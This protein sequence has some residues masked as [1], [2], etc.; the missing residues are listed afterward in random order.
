MAAKPR[1]EAENDWRVV[2]SPPLLC[3][4][5]MQ[6]V[7][8]SVMQESRRSAVHMVPYP[9]RLLRL[10]SCPALRQEAVGVEGPAQGRSDLAHL[11]ERP[12]A[13]KR[14]RAPQKVT[15]SRKKDLWPPSILRQVDQ[16]AL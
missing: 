5:A 12:G 13:E 6:R 7:P 14:S 1:E 11:L 9:H 3:W 4:V 15:A 2:S 8:M 10:S 16:N